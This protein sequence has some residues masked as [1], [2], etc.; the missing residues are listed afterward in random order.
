MLTNAVEADP[1]VDHEN[2]E[3]EGGEAGSNVGLA[4]SMSAVQLGV[5]GVWC[6]GLR[7]VKSSL[8]GIV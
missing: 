4:K 8:P 5:Y 6:A 2:D 7:C 1:C 3:D